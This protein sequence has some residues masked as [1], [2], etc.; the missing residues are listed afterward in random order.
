M[1]IHHICQIVGC[2][3]SAISRGK[4]RYHYDQG[5][6]RRHKTARKHFS[7]EDQVRF[8][9]EVAPA[10]VGGGCLTWPY[11]RDG[12]GY[13]RLSFG[14]KEYIVSRLVCCEVHG[15]P[16]TPDHEAA[17]SCGNGHLACISP[18]H[19]SWKTPAENRADAIA[20]GT[21][22][23][24]SN[25]KVAKL[26]ED[27]V[28]LIRAGVSRGVPQKSFVYMFGVSRG[29]VSDIVNRRHWAWVDAA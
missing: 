5:R 16:P 4:C 23:R 9:L 29:T 20:H 12:K 21:H 19:L 15:E 22:V 3:N 17:H 28:R 27:Q 13:G 11:G 25:H 6:E 26:N 1:A 8:L 18:I 24:G 2:S 7:K 14:G 10:H